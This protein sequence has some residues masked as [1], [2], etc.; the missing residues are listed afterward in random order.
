LRTRVDEPEISER[1]TEETTMSRTKRIEVVRYANRKF[2]RPD[3]HRY[4]SVREIAGR[5]SQGEDL[6][7][8]EDRTGEDVTFEVLLKILWDLVR[9]RASSLG[10]RKKDPFARSV[11]RRM[12]T[13]TM[14]LPVA[15]GG[16]V[17]S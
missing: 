16:R 13:A 5:V 2:Y 14:S 3:W 1:N 17:R 7:I 4:M 15:S 11:L 12:I 8:I 9:E 6:R 10:G